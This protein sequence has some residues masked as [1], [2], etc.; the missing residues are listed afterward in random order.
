MTF[1]PPIVAQVDL[2]ATDPRRQRQL[3]VGVVPWPEEAE[4]TTVVVK[5]LYRYAAGDE[6]LVLADEPAVLT[7]STVT[8]RPGALDLEREAPD[9]LVP[10]KLRA[11]VLV[12][13]HAFG[14][15]AAER[16]DASL[17]VLS[18]DD[19]ERLALTF[20]CRGPSP[21]ERMPLGGG[22]LRDADGETPLPPVGPIAP[23]HVAVEEPSV[24][25]FGMTEEERQLMRVQAVSMGA[26]SR[27]RNPAVQAFFEQLKAGAA[28]RVEE[29]EASG[30]E[31]D[32][33]TLEELEAPTGRS[34]ADLTVADPPVE[35]GWQ[36][37]ADH[38]TC[39]TV[40]RDDRIELTGLTPG[41]GTQQLALPNHD[42][43][44]IVEGDE[45]TWDTV[46]AIDTV[47]IDTDRQLVSL[48]WRGQ[49][50]EDLFANP[51]ARLVVARIVADDEPT[52]D[53]IYRALPRGSFRRAEVPAEADIEAPDRPDV[54]L[55]AARAMTYGETPEPLLELEDYAAIA[56]ALADDPDRRAETL[57]ARGLNED[58]WMLEQRAWLKRV[59]A[60]ISA[61]DHDEVARINGTL[62]RVKREHR[63]ARQEAGR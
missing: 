4:R 8:A 25:D 36:Q 15:R 19:R 50:P 47:L 27:E 31:D 53:A 60:A 13:G 45:T 18:S 12:V 59:G 44:V 55:E 37:A 46:M 32:L 51:S 43:V 17:R 40:G 57:A 28:E 3:A 42:V 34:W 61:N 35:A 22:Y 38:L 63:A 5:A 16:I 9:D 29:P 14:E 54:S 7:R 52:L 6:A 1:P 20:C 48:V 26:F 41:G 23:R 33:V 10:A 30:S 2:T 24:D 39:G 58:D 56:A 62:A 11:D 49:V 21:I